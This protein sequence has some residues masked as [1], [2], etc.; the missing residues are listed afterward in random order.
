MTGRDRR[1]QYEWR[2]MEEHL[3][4]RN[5]ISF[6]V[7]ERSA[8]GMPTAYLVTYHLR[9]ICGVERPEMPEEPNPPVFA[10]TYKM[11]IELPD[12]YPSID[13]LPVFRFLT[14]DSHGQPIPHPWH[15]NIRYYGEFAGK[16]CL[17]MADTYTDLVWGVERVGHYLRYDLYHAKNEPPF[18]EDLKVAKW[19]VEQGEPKGW[20]YFDQNP[21]KQLL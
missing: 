14:H 6:E 2:K 15:P 11:Q 4:G 16:V 13:G 12:N 17:N 21:E 8:A 7:T 20:I 1:L 18:P 9:S 10:N 5:D 3:S 19:V